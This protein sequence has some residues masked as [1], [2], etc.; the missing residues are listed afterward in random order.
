MDAGIQ[1]KG[2]RSE[3]SVQAYAILGFWIAAKPCRNDVVLLNCGQW[4]KAAG[5]IK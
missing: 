3:G 2:E 4:S 1:S 5:V